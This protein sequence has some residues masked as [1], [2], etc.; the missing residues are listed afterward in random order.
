MR[1]A[2]VENMKNTPLGALGMALKE[3]GAELEWFRA[4]DGEP[5]PQD[6][7]VHDA[8]VVLG[9]EQNARDDDTHPYLSELAQLMRRFEEADKAV[10]GICLGSQILARA[11]EAENLIGAAR[12]FGWKTVGVTEEG[13]ADPLLASVG[14]DFTIFEWHSD[15]FTLP[16]EA[17]RLATSDVARNQAYRIGRATYG[18]QF[19]F[20]ANADVID[21]WRR[22]FK[23]TIER[24]EPGW[25]ERYPEIAAK[26]APAAETAG[27]VIA[28]A[29]VRTIEAA[30]ERREEAVL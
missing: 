13:K 10:L 8:L 24:I 7:T 26:H 28:R 1:V 15:T 16:A 5:L 19:H 6:P 30:V 18:T 22:D 3:A 11:Y 2:I 23:E 29:W 4:W 9:G 20:E 25:L 21:S 27:L 14:D 17:V 12:E